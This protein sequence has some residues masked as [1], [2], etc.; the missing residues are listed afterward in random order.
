MTDRIAGRT[1]TR[2]R[3][4][5][6]T[7]V[8]ATLALAAACTPAPAPQ[9]AATPK[10][11]E[12]KPAAPTAA[13]AAPA[14][15]QPAA[16]AP[17]PAQAA[18]GA[19]SKPGE[20]PR[21]RTLMAISGSNVKEGKFPDYD[22]WNPYA[23]GANHQVGSMLVHEP[24]AF[25]SAFAD[26]EHLWLAEG[27]SYSPDFTELT[28]KTRSGITW[29]DGTPFSAEDVAYTF[30]SLKELGPK[31]RW[32]VDVQQFLQNAKTT[33]PNTVV[34]KFQVPAPRFFEFITYKYDIGVY[35]V[36]KHIFDGQDWTQLRHYD[37]GKGWPVTTGPWKVTFASPEQRILD[38]RDDWWAVKAGLVKQMPQVQRIIHTPFAGEQQLAQAVITNQCDYST[39]LQPATYPTVL[40]QN[41]KIITH[42][43]R[44]KPY[45][46]VDWWPVSLYL[47]NTLK[48]FDNPDVRWALSYYMNR[49]QIVEVG[50][51]GASS[52]F[53]MPF[54]S[55][56][57]LKPYA[58]SIKDLLD[59][60]PT[61]EFNPKKG[62]ALLEK[63]G[64]KKQSGS[65]VDAQGQKLKLEIMGPGTGTFAPVGPVVSELLKR[66]GIEASFSQPPD[67]NDRFSKG[68]YTGYLNG[69][70]GSVR[71]I[72]YTL[73]LYQSASQ[74]VPGG[75]LVNFPKWTNKKYDDI[76]D[77][78][79]VT[80]MEDKPKLTQLFRQAMEI[81]LPELP[82]V[83]LTE[84]HHRIPMN[85][86]YW[87]NWPTA[88]NPYVNGAFWHLTY[89]LV[90]NNLE[91]TQA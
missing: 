37:P 87:K 20:V 68:E 28:I 69:H 52:L 22:L 44:D 35:V 78:V 41:P 83:Q 56:P 66:Q 2:R 90:L 23:V 84:F 48:P 47:N 45:G 13:A 43:G 71:D 19:V 51:D 54:P 30:N 34:L 91:A 39:S 6:S 14:P 82:D 57:P 50:W 85:T 11:A 70:G 24:L 72:Y 10:P 81:W 75:H 77:Q 74:A 46:Y 1:A 79:F 17:A 62:D 55:Y 88:E 42:S 4:L 3:F 86:T 32:G 60:Y 67:A 89:Q 61:L 80:P 16:T 53:P 8:L 31:V 76:V 7:S 38:R 21:N 27:Y 59:K 26:K 29:S 5:Q 49:D 33:D 15:T 73:R 12:P 36:P 18:A 9:A 58:D 40:S 65:W 64:F 63:A 25:Y